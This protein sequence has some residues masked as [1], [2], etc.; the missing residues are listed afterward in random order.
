M[1][2]I[3]WN[4][5]GLDPHLAELL[6]FLD[7]VTVKPH[8][9][10]IQE[11][12]IYD[13]TL[14]QIPTYN[15]IHTFR[16]NKKGGG[17]AIYINESIDYCSVDITKFNDTNIEVSGVN[18]RRNGGCYVTLLSVY[19]APMIKIDIEHLK[20]LILNNNMIILGDFNAKNT[21]WGSRINDTRGKII[22]QFIEDNNL[23]CLNKGEA[24]RIN[25]NGSLS[26]LDLALCSK[27]LGMD[28]TCE[29]LNDSWGSDH[30]PLA[31][32]YAS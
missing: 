14:P 9:I 8:F 29:V 10:C 15:F 24:T 6:Y 31:L 19:I 25:Y 5:N 20:G 18:F 27:R 13:D 1:Y 32:S 23:V 11:T 12:W 21:L 16:S 28:I 17:S 22:E 4:A 26:H 7:Q 30:Y 2:L 3:S